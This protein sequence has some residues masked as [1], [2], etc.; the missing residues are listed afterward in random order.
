MRHELA[1]SY[2]CMTR[3]GIVTI[4]RDINSDSMWMFTVEEGM[5]GH[6][7][8]SAEELAD[9]LSKHETGEKEWDVDCKSVS[10]PD[11]ISR[12]HRGRPGVTG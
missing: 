5:V 11:H 3:I 10:I 8:H 4:E 9:R 6:R 12:W 7:Y 1:D 2:W